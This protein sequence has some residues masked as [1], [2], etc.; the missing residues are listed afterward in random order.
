MPPIKSARKLQHVSI[1]ISDI[2]LILYHVFLVL[3]IYRPFSFFTVIMMLVIN[4]LEI[5]MDTR[6]AI[7]NR[8][9]ELCKERNWT[10]NHLAYVS[11][12]PQSTIKSILNGESSNPGTITIKKIC[13]GFEITLCQFFDTDSFNSLD[14]EIK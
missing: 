1:S 2:S 14:Q 5:E 4:H 6:Q 12:V 10:P 11:A 3:V 9:L 8:I 13:D 7:S